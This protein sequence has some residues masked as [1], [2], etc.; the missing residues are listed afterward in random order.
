MMV[1]IPAG[2][3]TMGSLVGERGH[4]NDEGP[5]HNVAIAQPFAISQ[6]EV[7]FD[8]WDACVSYGDCRSV[9]DMKWGRDQRPVINITWEDAKTYVEWLARVT[10][11]P[12][13]LPSEAEWEY[14]ARAGKQTAYWW[15]NEIG[16]GN[17]NCKECSSGP[18]PDRTQPVNSFAANPFGLYNVHGNVWEWVEDCYHSDYA[19]APSNGSAWISGDCDRRVVRGGG[20][21][22]AP[23]DVRSARRLPLSIPD[24]GNNL[25][26]RIARTLT[27]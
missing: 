8:D 24:T 11:K 17:A 7:T 26:F 2:N 27:P 19:G 15:G 13:R 10:G 4:R 21:Y 23:A 16:D 1:V 20:W 18:L 14:A 22:S 12:Y 5:Q 3:F 25:G 6:F 9:D